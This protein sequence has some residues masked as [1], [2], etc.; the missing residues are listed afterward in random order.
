M[1]DVTAR[2]KAEAGLA[3]AEARYRALVEQNPTITYI[4]GIE[5]DRPT[6]YISPQTTTI[7]GYTPQDWYAEPGLWSR[8]VV[9]EDRARIE[10]EDDPHPSTYRLR[11]KDGHLVWIHDQSRLITDEAGHPRYWQGVMIDITQQRR[12]EKL[13][14]DLVLER[15]EADRLRAEDEMKRTFLQTV[16]HDLRTPLAAILGLAV[17]LERDDVEM[18]EVEQR[19]YA[20]RIAHNARKLDGMVNDLLDL[21]RLDRGLAVPDFSPVDLGALIRELVASSELV[22]GRRLA[23]DVAPI[24]I[25]ADAAMLERLVENLLGNAVKHT[26]GDSR[27]WIRVERMGEGV[28]M[29]VEDDGPGVVPEDR[30]RIFEPFRQG[31][32][33]GAGSGLGLALVVRFAE[34]HDG[35]A[36]VDERAGGGAA[37]RVFLSAD[38]KG[39]GAASGPS[40]TEADDHQPTGNGSSA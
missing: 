19:D 16:A 32:G 12:T 11:A 7:L 18:T 26:P 21:E 3:E 10:S 23:V 9:P 1:M 37:F 24:V 36:W 27:I 30:E 38:P 31:T 17:T 35:R 5:G 33:A 29:S 28:V 20:H 2:R 34:L 15:E 39:A 40:D 14:H 6:L 13:E 22:A 4:D 8:I 25:R